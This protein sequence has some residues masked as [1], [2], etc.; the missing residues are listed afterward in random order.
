M[1]QF[2]KKE[3]RKI[4]KLDSFAKIQQFINKIPINFEEDGI[5]TCMSPIN[6]L[7]KNK[8]HCIEGAMLAAAIIWIN[9]LG[10]PL[11]VDLRATT[12]DDDHVIAVFK[13]SKKWGAISKTNHAILRYREPVYNSIR[14][15]IMSFFHEYSDSKGNKTLREFSL[16][17]DLSIF[18]DLW[19]YFD[20]DLW[21]IYREL[22]N[23]KHFSILT[24]EQEQNL[25][26][27]DKIEIAL[28]KF[29]EWKRKKHQS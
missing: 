7:R 16:P 29:T 4:K 21:H 18:G 5:D 6:V 26:K 15:L 3:L 20:E 13:K 24:N 19:I 23:T 9:K 28:D 1:H 8:C 22:D 12:E 25:K 11:L 27:Q 17:L 14:E 2:T 10:K